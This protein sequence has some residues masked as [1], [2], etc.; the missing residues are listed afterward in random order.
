M[1]NEALSRNLPDFGYNGICYCGGYIDGR[2]DDRKAEREIKIKKSLIVIWFFALIIV[3]IPGMLILIGLGG[4]LVGEWL[5]C[6]EQKPEEPIIAPAA[7]AEIAEVPFIQADEYLIGAFYAD[8]KTNSLLAK[9]KKGWLQIISWGEDAE[10]PATAEQV[11]RAER[12]IH[13]AER[14]FEK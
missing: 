10:L 12:F 11:V 7:T 6:R 2:Q 3:V 9:T 1:G 14:R 4:K 5:I 13:A 8:D